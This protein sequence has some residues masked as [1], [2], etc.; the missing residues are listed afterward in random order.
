M[1]KG[2]L[3]KKI[4]HQD[5]YGIQMAKY[6][7][8]KEH[9]ISNTDW[10]PLKPQS[11]FYFFVPI[12]TK[13]EN[14]YNSFSTITDIFPL[15]GVGMTTARDNFV[16]DFDKAKL[17]DR[18][19]LFRDSNA[20]DKEL[21]SIFSI[22]MKKGWNIR[23]AWESLQKIV[24]SELERY[25]CPLLYRPFDR[26]YIF[27][28]DSLVWRTVRRIMRHMLYDNI[29]LCVGRAGHVVGDKFIWNLIFCCNNMTDFNL[30]YRGGNVTMPLHTYNLNN[31]IP[32]H[33]SM[34]KSRR[35]NNINSKVLSKIEVN[36][37]CRIKAKMLSSYVYAILYSNIYRRKYGG[38]L[39]NDFPRIPF[40]SDYGTFKEFAGLGKQLIELHLLKSLLLDRPEVRYYG[41]GK[42][43]VE[44]VMYDA[45][46]KRVYVN[47]SQY[48]EKVRGEV[49]EYQ[50][51][52]YQ[53]ME[54]WLKDRKKRELTLEEQ[55]TY[56]K[57][58]EAL[59]KTI[60]IQQ[61]I[62]RLYKKHEKEL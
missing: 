52:G 30:F 40:V 62:D 55:A 56:C 15:N 41:K 60:E 43:K 20:S 3:E 5:L 10:K 27:Y 2:K 26:R 23:E 1:K 35:H 22:N 12:D 24:D 42:D 14:R 54:K 49:W 7:Y 45:K 11:P 51:G 34:D 6:D 53:V 48:V 61:E 9:N 58:A 31:D 47:E 8:L 39:R 19:R 44:K 33:L 57:M 46:A 13:Y 21:H 36:Y 38:F 29:A 59:G 17:L 32:L 37:N 28:H 18:I 50:I 25:I 16:T 4:F